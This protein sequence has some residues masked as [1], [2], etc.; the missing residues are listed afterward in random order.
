MSKEKRN[1][2]L[3]KFTKYYGEEAYSWKPTYYS[4]NGLV[5]QIAVTEFYSD[6]SKILKNLANS[7]DEVTA[8]YKYVKSTYS[9]IGGY[10]RQISNYYIAKIN[11]GVVRKVEV[12]ELTEL[13]N[14]EVEKIK[15]A[16]AKYQ[17]KREAE[18]RCETYNFREGSVPGVHKPHWHRGCYYRH[19]LTTGSRKNAIHID[20]EYKFI[21]IKAKKL[22]NVYDDLVRHTDKSWKTSCKI[23]KQWMKHL[24]KHIETVQFDKKHFD[25]D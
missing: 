20:E 6:D 21:D 11:S 13:I 14:A 12:D 16:R 7:M 8:R 5:H 24:D 17:L 2:I 10:F 19:P 4:R 15:E 1:Y 3:F 9:C 23:R 25:F 18:K 22:P